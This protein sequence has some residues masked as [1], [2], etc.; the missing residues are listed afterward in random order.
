MRSL[1]DLSCIDP[2]QR[3]PD[4]F[5][6]TN[7]KGYAVNI[8]ALAKF[9]ER[10]P[11]LI[12]RLYE[13]LNY[14]TPQRIV[15]FLED[16]KNIPNR[17]KP[18]DQTKAANIA[19]SDLKD[20]LDQF[21]ILPPPQGSWPDT[22]SEE[23][24]S[25]SFDV[26]LVCRTW[27]EYAQQPLPPPD[28]N[29]TEMV[30]D[31]DK[32]KYRVPKGMV[33]QLFRQYPARAQ[34]FIAE[35]LEEEGWFDRS[36]WD[37]SLPFKKWSN[38]QEVEAGKYTFGR[39]AKFH[40]GRPGRRLQGLRGLW[41]PEWHLYCAAAHGRI[42]TACRRYRK[43]VSASSR[44]RILSGSPNGAKARWRKTM[45]PTD[46]YISAA[47]IAGWP[48]SITFF[49]RRKA[50]PIRSRCRAERSYSPPSAIGG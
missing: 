2:V 9:T 48:T 13:Q 36:G 6:T 18:I 14:T 25:E 45:M 27:Y 20:P 17:F 33:T 7:E 42:A 29:P 24:T 15:Q 35:T 23:M 5:W 26:F 43:R 44:T 46:S 41:H 3:N 31:Y 50:K 16:H 32:L 21:P 11:R 47:S 34:V 1:L 49:T 12:R 10:H 22:S 4:L 28:Q 19:K 30:P 38:L 37:A 8:A 39:E 40:S